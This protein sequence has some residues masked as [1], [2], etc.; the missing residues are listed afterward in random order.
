MYAYHHFISAT[1]VD[2]RAESIVTCGRF[3]II[4]RTKSL[5]NPL[6]KACVWLLLQRKRTGY[7]V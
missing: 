6:S 7:I 1:R 5:P 4:V 3:G 2:A